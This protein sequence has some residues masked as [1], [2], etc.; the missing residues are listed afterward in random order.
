MGNRTY[1]KSFTELNFSRS[2]HDF[3]ENPSAAN[4]MY[5]ERAMKAHQMASELS[6]DM[7]EKTIAGVSDREL[8]NVLVRRYD[9][10]MDEL[11]SLC[12]KGDVILIR[13]PHA[14]ETNQ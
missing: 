10:N 8:V 5:L 7:L 1:A 11:Q 2:A 13:A 4:W 12:L 14:E 3:R 9:L 6:D